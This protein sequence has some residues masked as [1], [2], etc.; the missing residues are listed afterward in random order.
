MQN[1]YPVKAQTFNNVLFFSGIFL[2][3]KF[4]SKHRNVFIMMNENQNETGD[5]YWNLNGE[6]EK[7]KN[8]RLTHIRITDENDKFIALLDIRDCRNDKEIHFKMMKSFWDYCSVKG[9]KT[10]VILKKIIE[11]FPYFT[12]EEYIE[13]YDKVLLN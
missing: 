1:S 8:G 9:E 6:I 12:W 7:W 3:I 11:R 5:Y 2:E 13:F 4:Y 10:Y